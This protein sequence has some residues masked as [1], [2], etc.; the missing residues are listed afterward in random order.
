MKNR[1]LSIIIFIL[2]AVAL[3]FS[4]IYSAKSDKSYNKG[5]VVF[6]ENEENEVIIS[7]D[8]ITKPSTTP[9]VTDT[10]TEPEIT[11]EPVI[12]VNWNSD[13]IVTEENLQEVIVKLFKLDSK[14][15]S[16]LAEV[17]LTESY[18]NNLLESKFIIPTVSSG[19]TVE[20]TK[21]GVTDNNSFMVMFNTQTSS[22]YIVG[23]IV[24]DKIDNIIY[25]ELK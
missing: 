6:Q 14:N 24:E 1:A 13:L 2:L 25:K 15:L 17:P 19:S 12:T 11:P 18:F 20:I 16:V 9:T 7:Q 8:V 23:N 22:Y 4:L 5:D 21:I 3:I 10:P